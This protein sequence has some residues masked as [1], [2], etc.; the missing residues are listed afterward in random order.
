[1]SKIEINDCVYKLHPVYDLYA[2]D[3]NGNIIN[4]IKKVPSKGN[5]HRTGYMMCTVRKY[6]QNGR[7]TCYV[8]RFVW[9]CFN[10]V[11]PE[12]KVIDDINDNKEDNR[13]CNLQLMTQ[14]QNNKKSAKNRDYT[15]AAKKS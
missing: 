2:S 1:M 5:K 14:Q 12:G 11:V 4:V 10:G 13:L 15:F 8:H 7:K 3:K 9:E 6:A